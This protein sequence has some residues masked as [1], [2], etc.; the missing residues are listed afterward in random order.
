MK[1][2]IIII[3]TVLFFE[4][5]PEVAR[6]GGIWESR[7]NPTPNTTVTLHGGRK[8]TGTLSMDWNGNYLLST[9]TGVVQFTKDSFE[10]MSTPARL[11]KDDHYPSRWRSILPIEI[12]TFIYF[13][14]IFALLWREYFEKANSKRDR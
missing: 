2:V 4:I 8:V 3:A 9:D 7:A 1:A 14:L 12:M 6:I 11:A 13:G 5:F 10:E